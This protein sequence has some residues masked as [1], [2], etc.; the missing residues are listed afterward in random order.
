MLNKKGQ[1]EIA[2]IFSV[3]LF[4]GVALIIF[5]LLSFYTGGAKQEVLGD[6]GETEASDELLV[7]LMT[8]MDDKNVADFIVESVNDVDFD[9]LDDYTYGNFDPQF[10]WI[11]FILDSEGKQ[12]HEMHNL[13]YRRSNSEYYDIESINYNPGLYGFTDFV[14][15]EE[16]IPNYDNEKPIKLILYRLTDRAY[17]LEVSST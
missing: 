10:E 12:L 4:V 8:P 14:T 16:F 7:Y 11:M 5:G 9:A 6:I 3:I 1:E 15:T 17:N 13:K 2:V